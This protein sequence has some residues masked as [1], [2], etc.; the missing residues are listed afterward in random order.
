[1][2]MARSAFGQDGVTATAWSPGA[3]S[4]WQVSMTALMPDAVIA[5]RPSGIATP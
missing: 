2:A 3:S 4:P 5:S 1:M